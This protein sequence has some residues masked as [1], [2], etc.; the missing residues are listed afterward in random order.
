VVLGLITFPKVHDESIKKASNSIKGHSV[1]RTVIVC[2][3]GALSMSD[4]N[5]TPYMEA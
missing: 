5:Q 3:L 2:S 1:S 4:E